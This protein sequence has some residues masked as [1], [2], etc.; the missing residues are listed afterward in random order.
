M[1]SNDILRSDLLDILFEHRNKDYG[2][3]ELRRHYSRRMLIS[4]S[5]MLVFTAIIF[6]FLGFRKVAEPRYR[7]IPWTEPTVLITEDPFLP[8]PPP[9]VIQR[10]T[11]ASTSI[12]ELMSTS[13]INIRPDQVAL[14]R[15][16]TQQDLSTA[17]PSDR[18]HGKL[19]LGDIPRT[20]TLARPSVTVTASP[21]EADKPF[22]PDEI[23]AG[24]PGG[25][26]A[27]RDFMASNLLTP[28]DLQAGE[29]KTV[30]VRF[31]IGADG[32][33]SE[34]RIVQSAGYAYD[35]EVL[36]V[37]RKMPRW[38]PARQNGIYVTASFLLP[39]TFIGLE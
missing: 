8:E 9:P 31:T 28:D 7:L 32:K 36:R 10:P 23:E 11:P 26:D 5:I 27:L 6:S 20:P 12:Q 25:A 35:Q 13:R 17:L 2:A 33:V 4:I 15:M 18:N 29:K 39:V 1:N 22:I 24:F 38:K 14:N 21:S 30:H 34:F 3:Y 19:P 37:C 16:S